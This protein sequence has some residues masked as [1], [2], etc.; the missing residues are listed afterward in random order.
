MLKK[1][2]KYC[3]I[4]SSNLRL[5]SAIINAKIRAKYLDQNFSVF[6]SG[7]HFKSNFPLE[8]INLNFSNLLKIFEGKALNFSNIFISAKF[9][10]VFIGDSLS[11]RFSK[12]NMLISLIK[13]VMPTAVVLTVK[14]F[15]NSSAIELTN[16]KSV[17]HND[18]INSDV[19]FAVNLDDTIHVRKFMEN[20]NNKTVLW[21]NDSGSQVA[22]AADYIIPVTNFFENEGI[23]L[24]L[25]N[26]PQKTLKT[27][28]KIGEMRYVGDIFNAFKIEYKSSSFLNYIHEIVEK[29]KLFSSINNI[30][31][32]E[33]A[34]KSE[35]L[36][37]LSF[38]PSKASVE[39]FYIK[40][41]FAKKSNVMLQCSQEVRKSLN[42]F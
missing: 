29:Y 31:M 8:F 11:R 5:E 21:L 6:G 25:E 28:P 36:G 24:N 34:Y 17:S 32:K 9:P 22:I 33:T 3:F 20:F 30:I 18:I 15:C 27:L 19:V 38:Y 23:F 35:G 7:Y 4:L 10:I 40:G 14:E 16:I 39:D 2:S 13:R 37:N 41:K 12:M 26:R 42:N 1:S